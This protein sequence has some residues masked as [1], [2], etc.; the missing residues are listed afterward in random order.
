MAATAEA[1][2]QEHRIV[3]EPQPG[4]QAALLACPI[5]E[6]FYGGARGGGKTDGSLGD[7][8]DHGQRYG[9]E[10]KGIFFR[11]HLTELDEAIER[12]KQIYGQAGADY[13]ESKKTFIMPGGARL[14]FRYLENDS[15][16]MAYQ[17]HSYTRV[18]MEELTNYP[19]PDPVMKLKATLRSAAG[20]PCGFRGTGNPGGPG[21]L[22]VK[23]RY[24]DPAP[25]GWKVMEEEF[26]NPF[27]GERLIQERVFIPAKLTDNQLLLLNDPGYVA[28]LH[29]SGSKELVRAWLEG[30]W[31]VV[32]GAFFPE[33][34]QRHVL[35]HQ[36]LPEWWERF[37]AKDWG[38]SQPGC[39]LYVAVSDGTHEATRADGSKF[40]IPAGSLV[41]YREWYIAE[42]ENPQQGLK[43][44]AE[45]TAEGIK[46]RCQYKENEN[47]RNVCDPSMW[48]TSGGPSIAER[49][50]KAGVKFTRAFKT[51]QVLNSRKAGWDQV[52]Y[53]L[54][55]RAGQPLVYVMDNCPHLIRTLPALLHD[56]INIEDADTDGEDHAPDTLRYACM[57]RPIMRPK[58][59]TGRRQGPKYGTYD[60]LM[61]VTSQQAHLRSKYR[62]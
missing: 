53:R 1:L 59:G 58:P 33:F 42:K 47:P 52:R 31:N 36:A 8:L 28:R 43:L 11:R 48:I 41:V 3:W 2:D 13:R 54:K 10:A 44:T 16:A 30:D 62:P 9:K 55:G 38:S 57:S 49:I 6:V 25:L 17:G 26:V 27:T 46:K 20:V 22:W 5:F 61:E 32:L 37:I 19:H 7:W 51:G 60:W 29:Q 4:P 23:A 56:P 12:A 14:K 35:P 21:H 34:G 50:M 15:D 24:I 40:I 18:Y 45:E 39:V